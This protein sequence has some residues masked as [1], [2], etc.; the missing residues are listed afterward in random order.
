[1][2]TLLF[3]A[4]HHRYCR[5]AELIGSVEPT[6]PGLLGLGRQCPELACMPVM[7]W[8]GLEESPPPRSYQLGYALVPEMNRM[9]LL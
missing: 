7:S 2:G 6:P 8:F 5:A 4:G 1:M 3:Q 9:S